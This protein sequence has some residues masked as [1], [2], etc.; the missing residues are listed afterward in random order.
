MKISYGFVAATIAAACISTAVSATTL[1]VTG[2]TTGSPLSVTTADYVVTTA[3]IATQGFATGIKAT[4]NSQDIVAW[5]LDLANLLTSPS[6]YVVTTT[7]F[8]GSA[9]SSGQ[10]DLIQALFDSS[11]ATVVDAYTNNMGTS[12]NTAVQAGFQI[13]LWEA[14]YPSLSLSV[15]NGPD[16]AAIADAS[17]YASNFMTSATNYNGAV[18][19]NVSYLQATEGSQNLVTVSPVPL[20]AGGLLLISA[21]GGIAVARRRRKS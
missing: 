12:F 10:K 21:L 5:C 8:V 15:T 18:K 19:Y 3:P 4:Y 2:Y 17:T 6:D 11:Y 7:P 14:V 20:P 9:L 13:A 1:T 16:A